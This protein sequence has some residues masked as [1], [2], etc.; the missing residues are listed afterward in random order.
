MNQNTKF[1]IPIKTEKVSASRYIEMIKLGTDNIEA[2]KFNLHKI[3]RP[4][5][6]G[7]FEVTYKTMVL[8]QK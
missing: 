6:F 5:D 4:G 7:T 3:G 2:V 8:R 1:L